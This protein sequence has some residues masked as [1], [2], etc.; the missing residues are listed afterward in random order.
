MEENKLLSIHGNI[1]DTV[2]RLERLARE[3]A[4]REKAEREERWAK[5]R[6]EREKKEKDWE[7]LHP[8]LMTYTYIRYY[9]STYY[10]Y[11]GVARKIKFYEWSNIHSVP[12]E[13]VY[14]IPFFRF[15]DE[16]GILL[17]SGLREKMQ[18]LDTVYVICKPGCDSLI[19]EGSYERMRDEYLKCVECT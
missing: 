13:F 18:R 7:K 10:S 11:C 8:N 6:E 1:T 2:L 15:L 4:E 9:N 12:R 17:D 14:E 5:E 16:C 19:L 3:K